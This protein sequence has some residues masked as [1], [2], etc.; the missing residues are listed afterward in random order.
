MSSLPLSF[1]RESSLACYEKGRRLDKGGQGSVYEY[2]YGPRSKLFAVK[3]ITVDADRPNELRIATEIAVSL[4][5]NHVNL[6]S[7][8]QID[9]S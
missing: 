1:Q 9:T 7:A 6:L 2:S 8:L 3:V 5:A 4:E